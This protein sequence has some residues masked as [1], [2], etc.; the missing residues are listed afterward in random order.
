MLSFRLEERVTDKNCSVTV[1][2]RP[3]EFKSE[4]LLCFITISGSTSSL[5]IVDQSPPPQ[6][7]H[8]PQLWHSPSNANAA[9]RPHLTS[10]HAS[11][12][13]SQIDHPVCLRI[14]APIYNIMLVTFRLNSNFRNSAISPSLFYTPPHPPPLVLSLYHRTSADAKKGHYHTREKRGPVISL[15]FSHR[16]AVVNVSAGSSGDVGR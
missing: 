7:H 12:R 14:V 2:K 4:Q 3:V 11:L 9:N 15:P 13:Q 10:G 8:L 5:L 1:L 16:H 6:L